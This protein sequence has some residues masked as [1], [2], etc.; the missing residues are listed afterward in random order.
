MC[1]VIHIFTLQGRAFA[2][3]EREDG[4]T[5]PQ[6]ATFQGISKD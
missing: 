3:A 4:G 5:G 6:G 1:D 2:A